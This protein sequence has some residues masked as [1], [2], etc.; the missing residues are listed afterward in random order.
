MIT[1]EQIDRFK[2]QQTDKGKEIIQ[3]LEYMK[4]EYCKKLKIPSSEI[5]IGKLNPLVNGNTD[6]IDRFIEE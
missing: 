2:F 6:K 4:D 1:Q 3:M 5:K